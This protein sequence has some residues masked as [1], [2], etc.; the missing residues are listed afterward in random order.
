MLKSL[1]PLSLIPFAL[2][3]IFYMNKPNKIDD[4]DSVDNNLTNNDLINNDVIDDDLLNDQ[5]QVKEYLTKKINESEY[6]CGMDVNDFN[7]EYINSKKI[8]DMQLAGKTLMIEGEIN[9]MKN[10]NNFQEYI[11]KEEGFIDRGII[12]K[13]EMD[14]KIPRWKKIWDNCIEERGMKRR[15]KKKSIKKKKSK[16]SKKSKKK[17]KKSKKKSRK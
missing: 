2:I 3:L 15:T 7:I 10:F 11:N 1:I 14:K 17:S 16:K 6:K 9:E 13:S 4:D 8:A 12:N 5:N